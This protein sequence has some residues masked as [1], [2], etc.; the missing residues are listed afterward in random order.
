V[1]TIVG[2]TASGSRAS[3]DDLR[4][5]WDE[6]LS[7]PRVEVLGEPA[8]RHGGSEWV[9]SGV[10]GALLTALVSRR[11]GASS[12]ELAE[13]AGVGDVT[14]DLDALAATLSRIPPGP[15]LR[16]GL[17]VEVDLQGWLV[18]ADLAVGLRRA[19]QSGSRDLVDIALGL[20][21]GDA[22][23]VSGVAIEPTPAASPSSASTS[24]TSRRRR[25]STPEISKRPSGSPRRGW[26]PHR[27][28]SAGGRS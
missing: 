20:W 24:R 10:Q 19:A 26:T 12:A 17:V 7:R 21:R 11:D 2:G 4:R 6:Q 5:H 1:P 18:D 28:V 15:V 8:L 9:L 23:T 27:G 25:P 14:Q 13:L 16:R 22:F 3:D